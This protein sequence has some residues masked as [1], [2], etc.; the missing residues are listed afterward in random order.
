[1][2]TSLRSRLNYGQNKWV[3]ARD[4]KRNNNNNN[5]NNNNNNNKDKINKEDNTHVRRVGHQ[6]TLNRMSKYS[7]LMD[8]VTLVCEPFN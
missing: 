5:S 8:A 3:Q 6:F 4:K 7:A 1:M 2:T